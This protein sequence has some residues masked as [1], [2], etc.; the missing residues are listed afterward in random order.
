MNRLMNITLAIA[1][2]CAIA[3]YGALLDGPSDHEAAQASA[4]SLQDAKKAARDA[5]RELMIQEVMHGYAAL[6][7]AK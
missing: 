2:G 6:G 3:A 5:K 4:D 1:I 7:D